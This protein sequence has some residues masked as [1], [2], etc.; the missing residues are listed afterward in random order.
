MKTLLF[1]VAFFILEKGG[2]DLVPVYLALVIHGRRTLETVPSNLRDA[3]A[4]E[5]EVLGLGHD[6]KPLPLPIKE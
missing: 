2:I 6:G 3:V 5:L 1:R 4:A